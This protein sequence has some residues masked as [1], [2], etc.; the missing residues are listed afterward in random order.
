MWGRQWFNWVA[1]SFLPA[2]ASTV[3]GMPFLPESV[4]DQRILLTSFLLD[5]WMTELE[6]ELQ[7][8]PE[9]VRIPLRGILATLEWAQ[10]GD[11]VAAQ[12]NAIEEATH[13]S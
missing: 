11:S 1:G 5:K 12:P 6:W 9:W 8:R 13:Q 7:D 4:H 2:Y 3:A 10:E